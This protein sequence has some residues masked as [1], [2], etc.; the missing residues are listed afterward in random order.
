MFPF[1]RRRNNL[2]SQQDHKDIPNI[3]LLTYKYSHIIDKLRSRFI[4]KTQLLVGLRLIQLQSDN[5]PALSSTEPGIFVQNR[6]L[7]LKISHFPQ[8]KLTWNNTCPQ[9]LARN[10]M[11]WSVFIKHVNRKVIAM[12]RAMVIPV[13]LQEGDSAT[14]EMK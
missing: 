10:V 3:A 2:K 7:L 8:R 4:N 11:P 9:E 12:T 13:L 5:S 6:L 1:Y 14:Y